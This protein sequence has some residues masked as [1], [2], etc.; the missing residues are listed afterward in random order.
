MPASD[1][2]QATGKSNPAVVK[3]MIKRCDNFMTA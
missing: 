3:T 2:S 1:K